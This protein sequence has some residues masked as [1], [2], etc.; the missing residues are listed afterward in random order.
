[1]QL[2][3]SFELVKA[4]AYVFMEHQCLIF[5]HFESVS[6]L[7]DYIINNGMYKLCTLFV[8]TCWTEKYRDSNVQISFE[9]QTL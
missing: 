1:M 7:V 9:Q 4:H 2:F 8:S 5:W 3:R 6:T